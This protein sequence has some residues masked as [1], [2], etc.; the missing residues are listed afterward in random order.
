[1]SPTMGPPYLVDGPRPL[2]P[3]YSLLA[4]ANIPDTPDPHWQNGVEVWSYPPDLPHSWDPCSSGSDRVK[5]E[6]GTIPLP[7]FGAFIV[8][9]SETC[10]TRSIRTP[11]EFIARATTAFNATV[12]YAVEQEF[13]LGT[14]MGLINPYLTDTN[15]DVLNGGA[16]TPALEALSW[17]ERAIA[18][19]GRKGLIHASPQIVTRWGDFRVKDVAGRLQSIVGTP[20]AAGQGY[21]GVEADGTGGVAGADWAFAT[22]PVDIRRS[23]MRVYPE[24]ISEAL[25]R[26]ENLVTYY[27]EETFA[28]DWDTV[29]QSGILVDWTT[30]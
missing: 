9:F 15:L 8:Y 1:M 13:A 4:T 25:L 14:A 3:D 23:G 30:A 26:S 10:T 21:S 6:G 12:S 28:V 17:L 11:E 18:T 29:L 16:A 27:V 20:V 5:A 19:T 2:P 24:N 22:G 7:Q